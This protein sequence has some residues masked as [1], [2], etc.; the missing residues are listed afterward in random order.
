MVESAKPAMPLLPVL[1]SSRHP[2]PNGDLF[3]LEAGTVPFDIARVFFISGPK[4]AVR[5]KHAHI[6]CSQLLTVISG[7]VL[8]SVENPSRSTQETLM[9]VGESLHL[10]PLHW[11]SQEFCSEGT[12]L[13]VLCDQ[14]Y[15]EADYL[16]DYQS[17]IDRISATPQ[18]P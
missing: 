16:R 15:D 14:P 4:G 2:A 9:A 8:V 12:V 13:L 1:H 18:R 17:F 6:E 5:G 3:V 11:A 10:P 7:S